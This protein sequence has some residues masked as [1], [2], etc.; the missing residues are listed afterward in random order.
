YTV[1]RLDGKLWISGNYSR[2]TSDNAHLYGTP[3]KLRSGEDFADVSIFGDITPAV[4][5]GAEYAYFNDHY[6]GDDVKVAPAEVI[7]PR[8]QF[9]A[10]YTFQVL[11][12]FPQSY[13]ASAAAFLAT[14]VNP[15]RA[16][17]AC[18]ARA[19]IRWVSV[20]CCLCATSTSAS[21]P[22]NSY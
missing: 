4:R 6:A 5:L 11:N 20:A 14:S 2:S 19:S 8:F 13:S 3:G 10:F 16:A 12:P 15:R 9:P 1:P 22:S 17:S 21:R 18:S 7:N